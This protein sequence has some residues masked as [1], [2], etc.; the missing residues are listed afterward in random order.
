M[1]TG[2]TIPRAARIGAGL[3]RAALTGGAAYGAESALGN[4]Q[5]ALSQ[6]VGAFVGQA[7]VE[8]VAGFL[9]K[10]LLGT[11]GWKGVQRTTLANLGNVIEH[12]VVHPST[13]ASV[14]GRLRSDKDLLDLGQTGLARLRTA[15]DS[16]EKDM[17]KRA[18]S[19]LIFDPELIKI[20]Q[21]VG[22]RV[23]DDL[24]PGM[25]LN[26]EN[27]R[28]GVTLEGALDALKIAKEHAYGQGRESVLRTKLL[29]NLTAV[30]HD[31]RSAIAAAQNAIERWLQRPGAPDPSLAGEFQRVRAMYDK[32]LEIVGLMRSTGLREGT[33]AGGVLRMDVL[34]EAVMNRLGELERSG[35]GDQAGAFG[36]AVTRGA[37][38]GAQD[39]QEGLIPFALRKGTDPQGP[40]GASSAFFPRG[41]GTYTE[42]AG[43]PIVPIAP[44]LGGI[45]PGGV[46][47]G[48]AV[49]GQ[50]GAQILGNRE[51]RQ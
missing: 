40:I 3:G 43:T 24:P 27:L 17:V 21:A 23:Q 18:G 25:K 1:A 14:F 31:D 51:R 28:P 30:G 6:G 16:F 48:G 45:V 29:E 13:G 2:S 33:P 50:K 15:F 22:K 32:G 38:I 7:A 44:G 5:D 36:R 11:M 10:F 37:P 46:R 49:A 34:Q 20:V 35:F 26:V 41:T 39:V 9:S 47:I 42:F 19:D 12:E 4:P 8:P